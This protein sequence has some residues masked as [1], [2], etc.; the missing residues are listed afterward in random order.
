MARPTTS[1]QR[2][3]SVDFAALLQVDGKTVEPETSQE[4]QQPVA[5]TPGA[6]PPSRMGPSRGSTARGAQAQGTGPSGLQAAPVRQPTPGAVPAMPSAA[7]PGGRSDARAAVQQAAVGT[8]GRQAGTSGRQADQLGS[9]RPREPPNGQA[10]AG[11]EA[12]RAGSSSGG[13][14]QMGAASLTD[15]AAGSTV[16]AAAAPVAAARAG[17]AEG[18][19]EAGGSHGGKE[20]T[21]ANDVAAPAAVIAGNPCPQQPGRPPGRS[22]LSLPKRYE[23]P[24]MITYATVAHHLHKSVRCA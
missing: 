16:V 10:P 18:L 20:N 1:P 2:G 3:V 6:A 19:R 22:L 8:S 5:G 9:S 21:V 23:Q 24:K 4:Q 17:L 13:V 15:R 14:R 11:V 7:G 12:G